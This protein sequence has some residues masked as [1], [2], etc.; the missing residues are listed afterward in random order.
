MKQGETLAEIVNNGNMQELRYQLLT[1]ELAQF[2]KSCPARALTPIEKLHS[3]VAQLLEEQ[4]ATPPGAIRRWRQLRQLRKTITL[5][6]LSI[7]KTVRR[8]RT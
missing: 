5:P 3:A 2:C 7:G 6:L 4:A 1:G 8:W